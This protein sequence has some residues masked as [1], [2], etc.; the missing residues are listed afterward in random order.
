M[1]GTA[2]SPSQPA[3]SSL[4]KTFLTLGSL[5]AGFPDCSNVAAR[6]PSG[7]RIFDLQ[8]GGSSERP[9]IS[10]I[11]VFRNKRRALLEELLQK[12]LTTCSARS[13]ISI[14]NDD[15]QPI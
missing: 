8:G 10:L 9:D 5:L 13:L 7:F 4:A 2:F 14:F 12:L 3:R 11:R 1:E 15:L 6:L